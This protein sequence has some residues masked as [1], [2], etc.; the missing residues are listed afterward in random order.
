VK[1]ERPLAG[2][3]VAERLVRL[4]YTIGT[5]QSAGPTVYAR[6]AGRIDV[7]V[8]AII[9]IPAGSPAVVLTLALRRWP[10]LATYAGGSA[11]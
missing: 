10:S 3:R 11:A 5:G 4:G 6:P 9:H 1:L 2:Q 8:A 7:D